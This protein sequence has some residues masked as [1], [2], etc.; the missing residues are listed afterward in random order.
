VQ[1]EVFVEFIDRD[2]DEMIDAFV[3]ELS[4]ILVNT[5]ESSC[6]LTVPAKGMTVSA[7]DVCDEAHAATVFFIGRVVKPVSP[8]QTARR[9]QRMKPGRGLGREI[10]GHR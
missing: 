6:V 1:V 9:S 2:A 7:L 5:D 3:D 10:V 4:L 8:G